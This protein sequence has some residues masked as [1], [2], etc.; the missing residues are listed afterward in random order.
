MRR[1]LPRPSPATAI[2]LLALF[3]AL[4][5]TAYGLARNSVGAR[6]L[7]TVKLRSAKIHDTDTTAADGVFN[8]A[9]GRAHCK[10]GEQLISGGV[11]LRD[12]GEVFPGQRISLVETAPIPRRRQW[13]VVLNS[14]LGGAARDK[15]VVF[16]VC[17]AR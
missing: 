3:V 10:R 1:K 2:A 15:L 6:E 5:G 13:A 17:L 14:D 11:R 8:L 12:I 9:H 7:D 16:A 4:G